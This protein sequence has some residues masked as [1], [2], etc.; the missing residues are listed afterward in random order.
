MSGWRWLKKTA[1]FLLFGLALY[2]VFLAVTAPAALLAEAATRLSGGMLTVTAPNG[3][4]WRGEGDVYAGG[5]AASVHHLGRLHWQINPFWLL[6]GRAHF[7]LQLQGAGTQGQASVQLSRSQVTVTEL[8]AALPA[9]LASLV[10]APVGFFGPTGTLQLRAPSFD[11][12]RGG[13]VT[14]TEVLWQGAGG[15]FAGAT[16]LGD[17]RLELNGRGET[18]TIRLSTLNGNL[19]LTGEGQWRVTGDGELQFTGSA[20]PRGD[21]ARLEPLLQTLGRDLGGGRRELR[22][23]ARVPVVRQLG[24]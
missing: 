21:T 10:Y 2:I 14:T 12:S 1:G 3:T 15:R 19:E 7:A 9:S 4:L 18:A 20:L 5:Q 23:N 24:L 17:Y 11:L 22:L 16:G 13:L 8:K 6:L